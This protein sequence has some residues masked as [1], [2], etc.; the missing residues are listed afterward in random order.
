MDTYASRFWVTVLVILGALFTSCYLAMDHLSRA[1]R[2]AT[3]DAV[4]GMLAS[5]HQAIK[6]WHIE[7]EASLKEWYSAIAPKIR[8]ML[9]EDP[10][11]RG[12]PATLMSGIRVRGDRALLLLDGDGQIL[13]AS[14]APLK[15]HWHLTPETQRYT[16][17][18]LQRGTY[19]S[20]PL[21]LLVQHD[22][23][24]VQL[25]GVSVADEA[26]GTAAIVS[27]KSV[28]TALLPMLNRSRLGQ[29]GE[30]YLFDGQGRL[31]VSTEPV[32]RFIQA[33]VLAS[34]A[35]NHYGVR[36][37]NPG[38]ELMPGGSES[39]P[40][41]ELPFIA[42]I[43]EALSNPEGLGVLE[44]RDYLG[45]EVIGAW[46]WDSPWKLGIVIQQR[47]SE[48]FQ[49][50]V[51]VQNFVWGAAIIVA[52]IIVALTQVYLLGRARLA[53]ANSEL[54]AILHNTDF[55][56]YLR[57][58]NDQV[59]DSNP[60]Y[61]MLNL[62]EDLDEESLRKLKKLE[63]Q[64]LMAQLSINE[65][66]W[67][68]LKGQR[69]VLRVNLFPV[70]LDASLPVH[71][72]LGGVMNDVT[73]QEL[74]VEQLN[75][76][77]NNLE[78]K[79]E[80]RTHQIQEQKAQMKA[81]LD[82]APDGIATLDEKGKVLYANARFASTY[83]MKIQ[84]CIGVGFHQLSHQGEQEALAWL[85]SIETQV[86]RDVEVEV[87]GDTRQLECL[88]NPF[89]INDKLFYSLVVRD[90]TK[91]KALR[92]SLIQSRNKAERANKMNSVSL[93]Y[94]AK[95]IKAPMKSLMKHLDQATKKY[96]DD[97]GLLKAI[98][99]GNLVLQTILD[100]QEY[101]DVDAKKI[102]LKVENTDLY[103]L[104]TSVRSM[105][106]AGVMSQQVT[107]M[108][109]FDEK[110]PKCIHID[111]I[112]TQRLMLKV[113]FGS[114]LSLERGHLE[115][116][117]TM[118]ES[119]EH[120]RL[121]L[122]CRCDGFG[123]T[124]EQ[125]EI[126]FTSDQPIDPALARKFEEHA[127]NR[128]WFNSTLAAMKG[129]MSLQEAEGVV[130][131][132]LSL[133]LIADDNTPLIEALPLEG[134][135]YQ[136]L[137]LKV[138]D[139]KLAEYLERQVSGFGIKVLE[140]T[141]EID[142]KAQVQ[143]FLPEQVLMLFDAD[144]WGEADSINILERL[145]ELSISH[146]MIGPPYFLESYSQQEANGHWVGGIAT[147]VVNLELLLLLL[148]EQRSAQL[149][150]RIKAKRLALMRHENKLPRPSSGGGSTAII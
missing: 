86:A 147:P 116:R 33:G 98:W 45:R 34:S 17:R 2:Q 8:E 65:T 71:R 69:R 64:V 42:P 120:Q 104:F 146:A 30:A 141:K 88:L 108:F 67:V 127:I 85:N 101:S 52:L 145:T 22:L 50:L 13:W 76:Y 149:R 143:A 11:N 144:A 138:S 84:E 102:E 87:K 37:L 92:H 23:E 136:V 95:E 3:S 62:D 63:Q 128:A 75:V 106:A 36:L 24:P 25:I 51:W 72:Y 4:L 112:R 61:Q 7:E 83:S 39:L 74:L 31:L 132:Q 43:E 129:E 79:V 80:E 56:I 123:M 89:Y 133:P 57:D 1:A 124:K 6:I 140:I 32:E 55:P 125:L 14:S 100:A 35:T 38:I 9:A 53:S 10:E 15:Q 41:G 46:L 105:L 117:L 73:E 21:M 90:V 47:Q 110:L 82:N 20:H 28:N 96:L 44:F 70:M 49:Y 113:G 118:T 60:S 139:A 119:K 59:V 148:H 40:G 29:T 150:T 5:T 126:V 26:S 68:Y 137:L 115:Y 135:Q 78:K 93:D 54:T 81:L 27:I 131:I 107:L 48:A 109:S 66:L 134:F 77:K 18:L 58:D 111:A 12:M 19:T 97:E 130:S 94:L 91:E 16:D 99:A 114:L 121:L 122:E 103:E 142:L